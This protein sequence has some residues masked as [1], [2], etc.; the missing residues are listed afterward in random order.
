MCT[1]VCTCAKYV[2]YTVSA[3]YSVALHEFVCIL[4]WSFAFFNFLGLYT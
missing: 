3:V 1:E 2:T 4:L